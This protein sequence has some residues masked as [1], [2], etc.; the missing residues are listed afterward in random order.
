MGVAVFPQA[1]LSPDVAA[2]LAQA[3]DKAGATAFT[4][5]YPTGSDPSLGD[6]WLVGLTY[7]GGLWPSMSQ[8]LYDLGITYVTVSADHQKL[9]NERTIW[10]E[11][12]RFPH[13]RARQEHATLTFARQNGWFDPTW[14]AHSCSAH[15]AFHAAAKGGVLARTFSN[16]RGAA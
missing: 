2:H 11:Q 13:T 12:E 3:M 5:G 9:L 7:D 10:F 16:R 6:G 15:K 8:I 4:D 14:F 1:V